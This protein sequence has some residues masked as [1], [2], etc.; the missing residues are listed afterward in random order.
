MKDK[1]KSDEFKPEQ[2]DAKTDYEWH[3]LAAQVMKSRNAEGCTRTNPSLLAAAEREPQASPA[4]AYRLWMADNLSID[5]NYTEAIGI[6][7]DCVRACESASPLTA[8]QDLVTGALMHKAQ[9]LH[10][11]GDLR[12]ALAAYVDLIGQRPAKKI[13]VFEAGMIAERLN[14][15]TSAYEYYGRIASE[16]LTAKTDDP[17]QLARRA[18]E[19]L[20]I[21]EVGYC[22]SATKLADQLTVA[23]ER[24]DTRS[25]R[26]CASKTHFSIG[27]VGGHTGFE[28]L[29]MLDEF[30]G[31]LSQSDVA[32]KRQLLGSGGKRYLPSTGWKG[33][34]FRGDVSLIITEAPGGWQW[35]GIALHAAN[36]HWAERW[37]PPVI[38]SNDPLPFE[39]FAPWPKGQCFTAGGLW[40]H[41]AEAATVAAAWPFS[42]LVA[43]GFASANC[44]GWGARGFYYN[45]GPTHDEEDAFAI[46]FTRYRRFVPYDN[47]SGGTPVLAV[48][49][50]IVSNVRAGIPSGDSTTDN[51]VEIEH[52]DPNNPK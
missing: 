26:H 18:M 17:A 21:K 30:L 38:Q 46:D 27:P 8:T 7:D 3:Q 36:E 12:G 48:R 11:S 24:G 45:I 40:E 29:E 23:L 31:D 39:I 37:K 9:A 2:L 22:R 20:S 42:A 44:C 35:T 13:A 6:Y 15:H 43:L 1:N 47:E 16:E 19:R 33:K 25:L 41:I 10:L 14:D 5:G 50:G 51:R 32:V 52:S 49:E 34:W 28:S 4:P